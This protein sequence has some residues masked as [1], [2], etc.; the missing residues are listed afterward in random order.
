MHRIY[1]IFMH[2]YMYIHTMTCLSI[3]M[4][5]CGFASYIFPMG[6][7]SQKSIFKPR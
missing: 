2:V 1:F 7:N 3:S 4:S 6:T 5:A